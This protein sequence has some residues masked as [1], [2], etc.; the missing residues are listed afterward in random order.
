MILDS[1]RLRWAA[2][3]GGGAVRPLPP[4]LR[5]N[6]TLFESATGWGISRGSVL[7]RAAEN[8]L[9]MLSASALSRAVHTA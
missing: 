8:M 4:L 2:P 1:H 3:E 9:P 6:K 5:G 7:W